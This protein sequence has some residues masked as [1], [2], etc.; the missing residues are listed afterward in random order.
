MLKWKNRQVLQLETNTQRIPSMHSRKTA[1]T[2]NWKGEAQEEE[3]AY[4][5]FLMAISLKFQGCFLQAFPLFAPT[6][7]FFFKS[8]SKNKHNNFH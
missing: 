5:A 4:L 1:F 8:Q 3:E 6:F 2:R 7:F